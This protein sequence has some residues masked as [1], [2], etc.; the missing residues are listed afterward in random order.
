[1]LRRLRTSLFR[2]FSKSPVSGSDE[3]VFN[4][5]RAVLTTFSLPTGERSDRTIKCDENIPDS[6]TSATKQ[7][8]P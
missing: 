4:Q 6:W 3:H 1:M 2:I 8:Y 5:Q 7:P